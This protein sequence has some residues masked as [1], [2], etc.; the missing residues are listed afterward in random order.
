MKI[1]Y[2]D[3]PYLGMG[4]KMYGKLH[5]EAGIWDD[6]QSHI[7]LMATLDA[8]YDA[9]ALSLTST[10]LT[11]LLPGAP[12]GSR[13]GAWVK[14]FAAWR[15]NHRV[16]YTW[17]PIIF[18]TKRSKGGKGIPSVRDHIS[19]NIAMKKGLQG[20]KPDAFNDYI[21]DLL[22]YEEG[23]V[24]VDLFPGTGGMQEAIDRRCTT[25]VMID[26]MLLIQEDAE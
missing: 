6:P 20:A 10:S 1:A 11:L 13:V 17:E 26:Q 2:A 12:A 24:F 23:D 25:N 14:P 9:W 15:P 8:E 5:P 19:C 4:K 22:G 18:R 16:Q 7:D 3:P 21:I